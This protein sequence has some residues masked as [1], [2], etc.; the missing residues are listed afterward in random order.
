MS[1]TDNS[2]LEV[3]QPAD[4]H[5][6]GW[7]FPNREAELE[8]LLR[9]ADLDDGLPVSAGGPPFRVFIPHGDLKAVEIDE[10]AP[11]DTVSPSGIPSTPAIQ[12][13]QPAPAK[14]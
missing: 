14:P 8:W 10:N 1:Q 3:A 5:L 2:N 7:G 6:T 9:T 12:T 4:D 13:E 11:R